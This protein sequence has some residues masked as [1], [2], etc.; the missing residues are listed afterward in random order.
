MQSKIEKIWCIVPAAGIG[1]RMGSTIPKQYL[2]LSSSTILDATLERLLSCEKINDIVV[3]IQKG[4]DY[5]HKSLFVN[6]NRITVAE[7]GNERADSVLN[8]ISLIKDKI[9]LN[10]WVLVHDAARPCVR[11][12]DIDLLTKAAC[13][14]Q[15][16]A[17][18]ASPIHDT[19]KRVINNLSEKTLDRSEIWHALTPQVFKFKELEQALISARKAGL[20][21]TDEASAIEQIDK[22]VQIIEGHA[23]NIKITSPA[24]LGLA[25]YYLE[26]QGKEQC[27]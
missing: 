17:I 15:S 12:N 23:D 11:R 5:W 1:S 16:G 2:K 8:G 21:V 22:P 18:L 14:H 26:Q 6:D 25:R 7:G 10:D 4:D 20:S 13:N 3:C 19:V 27:G 24:D 9:G